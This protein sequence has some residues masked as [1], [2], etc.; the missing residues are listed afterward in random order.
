M[1]HWRNDTDG[2]QLK[3]AEKK[4]SHCHFF[5]HKFHVDR[6][7]IDPGI[8]MRGYSFLAVNIHA[9]YKSF[10]YMEIITQ[11]QVLE[12]HSL[13]YKSKETVF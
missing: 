5:Q 10:P 3:K 9:H 13:T 11:V 12:I 1:K 7:R 6:P 8:G 4:L 2:G